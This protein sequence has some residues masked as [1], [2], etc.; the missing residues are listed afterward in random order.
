MVSL[1]TF[2]LDSCSMTMIL[3]VLS[4]PFLNWF[5]FFVCDYNAYV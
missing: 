5:S 4:F 3:V 1:A 2:H